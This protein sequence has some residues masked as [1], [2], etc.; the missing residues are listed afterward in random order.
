MNRL[1]ALRH[2][3]MPENTISQ[4]ISVPPLGRKKRKKAVNRADWISGV[5]R[6]LWVVQYL[7]F[8]TFLL[9]KN[10]K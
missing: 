2:W 6:Y 8:V 3:G 9:M 5:E 1:L 7:L 4:V 10:A